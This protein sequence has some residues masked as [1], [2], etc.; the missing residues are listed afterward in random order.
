MKLVI[1]RKRWQRGDSNLAALLHLQTGKMCCLGFFGLLC[2][3][4]EK[5]I[6]GLADPADCVDNIGKNKWPEWAIVRKERSVKV[7]IGEWETKI[8]LDNTDDIE[9]LITANDDGGI[10]DEVREAKITRIFARNGV[11]VEFV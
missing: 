9:Q 8:D 4:D 10:T 5:D 1:D 3:Y 6:L 2:G 7:D 11:E